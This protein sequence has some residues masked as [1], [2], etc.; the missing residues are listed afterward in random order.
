MTGEKYMNVFE[1]HFDM[2]KKNENIF[3][4]CKIE[5]MK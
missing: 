5:E 2:L 3:E 4:Q 1:K